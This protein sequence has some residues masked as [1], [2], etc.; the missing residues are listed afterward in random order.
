VSATSTTTTTI[1]EALAL[2]HPEGVVF[3]VRILDAGRAGTVSGYFDDTDKAAAAIARYDGKAAGVYTT[4]NPVKVE[5]LAR[6]ENKLKERAKVTTSDDAI[7]VRRWFAADLDAERLSGISSTNAEVEASVALAKDVRAYLT[8]E[9]WPEPLLVMSGNG[10]HLWYRIQLPNDRASLDLV[11]RALKALAAKFGTDEVKVDTTLSNASRILKVPGTMT[12]KGDNTD[13]RPHRRSELLDQ[14]ARLTVVSADQLK[15]IAGPTPTSTPSTPSSSPANGN[16]HSDFDVESF[17]RENGLIV[18]REKQDAGAT[19]WELETCPFNGDHVHGEAWVRRAVSGSLSAGCQHQSCFKSWAELRERFDPGHGARQA[20][21]D[22]PGQPASPV[23]DDVQAE[24]AERWPAP[25]GE[26]A[27][28]GPIGALVKLWT[29]VNEADPA[30][31]LVTMLAGFGNVC[32]AKCYVPVGDDRHP[33]RLFGLIVG[34]SANSRKGM[35]AGP[36][37]AALELI[38]PDWYEHCVASGLSTGEGLIHRVRNPVVELKKDGSTTT[39]DAGTTDKRLFVKEG[40]LAKMFAVMMREG[41]T[42]SS[43]IRDLY[44]TGKSEVITRTTPYSTS[45]AHVSLLGHITREEL[46]AKLSDTDAASGFANRWVFVCAERQR[47]LPFGGKASAT[48][49]EPHINALRQAAEA[50][51]DGFAEG[52]FSWSVEAREVWLKVYEGLTS[53]APGMAGN[54]LNRGPAQVLRM[55]MVYTLADSA[56]EIGRVHLEAALEVWRYCAASV[57]YLFGGRTG[58]SMADRIATALE[59]GDKTKTE[60]RDLFQR[61]RSAAEVDAALSL[62]E[63]MGRAHQVEGVGGPGR[64]A[65]TWRSGRAPEVPPSPLPEEGDDDII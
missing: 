49:L 18:G 43:T 13:E 52:P 8:N 64:P 59:D 29:P 50:A 40:E 31:M 46:A 27:Y 9:G 39:T 2:I 30:A 16:G 41:N 35:S 62:L 55:A 57:N 3:E 60:I 20:R 58:S 34:K 38:D 21:Q 22:S 32:G 17:M 53:N 5:A 12:C 4:I 56:A 14:P 65:E 24:P 15:A 63:S 54:L 6:S 36:P 45:G 28:H 1:A 37:M 33:P 26:A 51:T 42:L 47:L 25:L 19:I 61:H 10:A 23:A 48:A 44:D 11:T 7:M